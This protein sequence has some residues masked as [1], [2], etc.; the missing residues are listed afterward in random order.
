MK[1]VLGLIVSLALLTGILAGC[2]GTPAENSGTSTPT[3]TGTS[4]PEASN[5]PEEAVWPRTYAD[6]LGREVVI[7]KQ[8][9]KIVSLEHVVVPDALLALGVIPAGATRADSTVNAFEA[10][11][12]YLGTQTVDDIGE[13]ATP[14]LEKI[15]EIEPD[16]IV[17]FTGDSHEGLMDQ[18]AAISPVVYINAGLA[19]EGDE[20]ISGREYALQEVGKLIGKEM[21]AEAFIS[22]LNEKIENG[23]QQLAEVMDGKTVVICA[24]DG[25]T[26]TLYG[27]HIA[28]TNESNGLGLQVPEGYPAEGTYS[29]LD[30]EGLSVLNPDYLFA[31][32]ITAEELYEANKSSAVW[33]S[34]EAVKN[35]HVYALPLG[36][37][38]R[39][40]PISTSYGIDVLLDILLNAQ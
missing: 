25:K 36:L 7:E 10:Y 31:F 12:S 23:R 11:H 34:L 40:A 20:T 37:F 21:Q 33:N 35:E 9:E 39:N 16:L 32:N 26:F 38:S 22:E 28:A 29:A 17:A 13:W 4:T 24:S 8:P 30:L 6:A 18:L 1:R 19:V 2:A 15:L 14:N 5:D 27:R 3:A